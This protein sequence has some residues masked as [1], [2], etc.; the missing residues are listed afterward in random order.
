MC[1]NNSKIALKQFDETVIVQKKGL[2]KRQTKKAILTLRKE[3]FES[4]S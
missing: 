2:N 1:L 3:N 4:K